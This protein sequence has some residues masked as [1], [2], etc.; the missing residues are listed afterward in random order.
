MFYWMTNCVGISVM[1]AMEEGK[2]YQTLTITTKDTGANS[3]LLL[4]AR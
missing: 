2:T 3:L 1:F 4:Y